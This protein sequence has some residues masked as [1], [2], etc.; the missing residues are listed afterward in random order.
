MAP[1]LLSWGDD[2]I[3]VQA[4]YNDELFNE[5]FTRVSESDDARARATSKDKFTSGIIAD[6]SYSC[7]FKIIP[8]SLQVSA[9]NYNQE[10]S[11]KFTLCTKWQ[12]LLKPIETSVEKANWIARTIVVLHNFFIDES[13]GTFKP[14]AMADIETKDERDAQNGS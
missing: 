11:C 7:D 9:T 13:N 14:S 3:S 2:L 5:E 1:D 6:K 4:D 12:L 10:K 8:P